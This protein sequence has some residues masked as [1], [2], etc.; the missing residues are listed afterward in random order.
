MV[1]VSVS[2]SK[3]GSGK[4]TTSINLGVA[5]AQL[6]KDV[7]VIDANLST[8]NL[9]MYLGAPNLPIT[10]HHVLK[11]E[12]HIHEATYQH[13]SGA[14]IIPASIS[15]RNFE[16]IN[17]AD[18][19]YHL[20]HIKSEFI[21]LDGAA[22]IDA[23]AQAPIQMSDQVLIVAS[24][25]LPSVADALKTVR[26]AQHPGKHVR[27]AVLTRAGHHLDLKI[28]N[29][30][31]ILEHP[32]IGVVPEDHHIKAALVKREPVVHVFP[33]SPS[34]IAYK[35]LASYFAGHGELFVNEEIPKL[36]KAMRWMIGLR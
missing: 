3:G 31:T 32:V 8:P 14:K 34:A 11:G 30:E 25:E 29:V 28:K 17:L 2:S 12:A 7:T 22:G 9:S 23:E 33:Q 5:L 36:Y 6:G 19:Q 24:P 10:L 27:G 1:L 21:I 35:Q 18:L 26:I 16:N 4:S 15:M 13:A 20:P